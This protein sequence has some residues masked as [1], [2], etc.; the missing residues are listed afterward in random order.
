MSDAY[1]TPPSGA[2]GWLYGA[3][4][5]PVGYNKLRSGTTTYTIDTPDYVPITSFISNLDAAT[6]WTWGQA[7]DGRIQITAGT[8]ELTWLDRLGWLLGFDREGYESEG[9]IAPPVTARQISPAIIPLFART[10]DR[11]ERERERKLVIDR[12]GRGHGYVFGA[13]DIWRWTLRL[14]RT[15]LA[16]WRTGWCARGPIY[17]S[18]FTLAQHRASSITHHSPSNPG[19]LVIC[20]VLGTEG[21]PRPIDRVGRMYELTLVTARATEGL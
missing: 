18:P 1:E 21:A 8:N 10:Y 14:H 5:P 20:R 12:F 15:G 7:A 6:P 19:G 16:A 2:V 4:P 11:I 3:G 17:L 13:A 9:A